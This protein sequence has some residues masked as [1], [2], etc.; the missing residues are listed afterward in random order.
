MLKPF[1]RS[2]PLRSVFLGRVQVTLAGGLFGASLFWVFGIG[3]AEMILPEWRPGLGTM[4]LIGG[5]GGMALLG[6][7]VHARFARGAAFDRRVLLIGSGRLAE[8]VVSA[9][10]VGRSPY[11]IVQRLPALSLAESGNGSGGVSVLDLVHK[12]DIHHIVIALRDGRGRFPFDD[13]LQCKFAGVTIEDGLSF[14]ERVAGKVHL[15]ALKPSWLI[16]SQGFKREYRTSVIKRA[17][18]VIGSVVGLTV[19]APF[20][21]ILAAVIKCDSAGPVFYRQV[22]IG[23]GEHP[24]T[25]LKFRSMCCDAE[26]TTGPVWAKEGDERVTRVGRWLRM[27]RI[28]ELPQMVNVLRGQ[29]SFVG[30]RPERPSFV[31]RL[32]ADIPYYGLRHAV[33]PG[34][35]G[36]AQTRYTYGASVEDATEKLQ[37]DLSYIKNHSLRLDLSILLDTFKIVALRR[38]AR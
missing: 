5:V 7:A 10:K 37:Y 34:I 29:M 33:K 17:F 13:L 14:Y 18:D 30:P 1:P 12:A 24:F 23:A 28:D 25:L 27:F 15:D 8:D 21:L 35:T 20:G 9:L 6:R 19:L 38:G 36:L 16:F 11:M 4:A 3:G 22:R 2:I 31:D 26:R 32:K